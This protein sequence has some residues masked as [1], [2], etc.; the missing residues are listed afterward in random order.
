MQVQ[1]DLLL[2]SLIGGPFDEAAR[3]LRDA[4]AR[5]AQVRS[6]KEPTPSSELRNTYEVRRK[7]LMVAKRR[8]PGFDLVTEFFIAHPH[9]SWWLV[10]IDGARLGGV[11]VLSEDEKPVAC[12]AYTDPT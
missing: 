12:F 1:P 8:M 5:G 3:L 4:L 10:G 9:R 7:H 2:Q 11:L 6:P